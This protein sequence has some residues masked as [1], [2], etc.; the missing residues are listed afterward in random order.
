LLVET[1]FWLLSEPVAN[2][3]G[4]YQSDFHLET[5]PFQLLW[6]LVLGGMCLGLLG[7]WLAVGRH[8]DAIEPT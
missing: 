1:G 8:L 3:A 2:L 4:L 6:V 5:L 7:S